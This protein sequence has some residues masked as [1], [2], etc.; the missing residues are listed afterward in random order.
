MSTT[1][2]PDG[3]YVFPEGS[4]SLPIAGIK[5]GNRHRHDMGDIA[6][7]A[8]N[9]KENCLLHP[10]VIT[11]DGTLV[12]GQRRIEAFRFLGRSE[13][14]VRVVDLEC[15]VRGEYAENFFRKAFTP[16][17]MADIADALEPIERRAAKERQQEAGRAKAPG[18]FPEAT[19]GR[20]LDHIARLVGK[21]RK[22]ITKARAVRDAA[23]AEPA[24]F[25]KLLADMDR[26]GRVNG[27]FKRLNIARQA[28]AIRAE[29]PPY[30]GNGPY[31]VITAD[32]PWPYDRDTDDPAD[33]ATYPYPQMSIEAI[34]AVGPRVRAIA[35]DDCILWFWTTNRYMREAFIVLGTWGFEQKNILTWVKKDH[36]GRGD[37]LRGQTEHCLMAVRGKP[38]VELTNQTTV[39]YA[40]VPRD[41]SGRP[42]HS[43]KPDEF[44]A[45]VEG[46]C[47][48]PRYAEL[49]QRKP[50]ERWD[51]H[52]DE[53]QQQYAAN[54][55]GA[56]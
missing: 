17:E 42:I 46:L 39:L 7:L 50:R 2:K 34:C 4:T 28:E 54:Q 40:T 51:G 48:A 23:Q 49:F 20:A 8:A 9:I 18:K 25:G 27:P 30:P 6:G 35:H 41:A 29:P 19:Q 3:M 38:V 22:T 33:R 52:G 56:A 44:Y 11:S 21:D 31:R 12:A 14:P 45:F 32:V 10:V 15:V 55:G 13:I 26:T 1:S 16:S 36:I 43:A 53:V 5:I 24:R 47:P 37:W